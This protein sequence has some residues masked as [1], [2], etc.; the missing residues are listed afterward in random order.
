MPPVI[1]RAKVILGNRLMLRDVTIEDAEF[2]LSLRLDSK[3]SAYISPVENNLQKQIDWIENYLKNDGQAY[4]IICD[5]NG[6][7]LGTVR[8]YN[9]IGNSFSWGSW[10]LKEGAPTYAAIESAL[11]VYKYAIAHLAFTSSHF[12]VNGN[13]T[14]VWAFHERF[15][16]KKIR[17][18]EIEYFYEINS[19]DIT[20]SFL[21]Y[22][23][24]LP[25]DIEVYA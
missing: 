7:N 19:S 20:S 12:E 24:F 11:I 25:G 13:N 18:S 8:L 14:S 2:I 17:E 5:K 3:K 4:F 10:I 6:N 9:S 21:R 22:S 15:G 23:K 16:A 1:K